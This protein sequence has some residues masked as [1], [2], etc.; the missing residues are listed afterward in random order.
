MEDTGESKYTANQQYAIFNKTAKICYNMSGNFQSLDCW[1]T[2]NHFIQ[3]SNRTENQSSTWIT[4][5]F[6]RIGML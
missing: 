3:L 5:C 6:P 2:I 4:N 1:C